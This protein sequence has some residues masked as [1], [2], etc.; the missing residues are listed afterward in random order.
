MSYES[1][2]KSMSI[3]YGSPPYG[4]TTPQRLDEIEFML[5]GFPK[6][7]DNLSVPLTTYLLFARSSLR[8]DLS[9]LYSAVFSEKTKNI[10]PEHLRE[11]KE[12]AKVQVALDDGNFKAEVAAFGSLEGAIVE[13]HLDVS[14]L[15]RYMAAIQQGMLTVVD[16]SLVAAACMKLRENPYLY[17]AYGEDYVPLMP[18]AWEDL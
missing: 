3:V 6:V 13:P 4:W 17:F 11:L 5:R 12:Q 1:L 15:Y 10:F 14:P 16:D 2:V 7:H 8:F 9:T 18:I